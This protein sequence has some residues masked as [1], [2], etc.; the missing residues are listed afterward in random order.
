[1][2]AYLRLFILF[3]VCFASDQTLRLPDLCLREVSREHYVLAVSSCFYHA[4]GATLTL[5]GMDS[6][7]TVERRIPRVRAHARRNDERVQPQRR[8]VHDGLCIVS[9]YSA[10]IQV[11]P[12]AFGSE[13]FQSATRES[14][15]SPKVMFSHTTR[16]S[17]LRGPRTAHESPCGDIDTQTC[18]ST[19]WPI[20]HGSR[21]ADLRGSAIRL[22]S[23]PGA[24]EATTSGAPGITGAGG[25]GGVDAP[26]NLVTLDI[27][28]SEGRQR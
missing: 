6:P 17:S 5:A 18:M 14:F 22:A 13:T 25:G 20:H 23:A 24:C 21:C 1:M 16:G 27:A 3:V 19:G 10:E 8:I 7:L 2:K 15:Q 11:R 4:T 28:R 9:A 12:R 26:K